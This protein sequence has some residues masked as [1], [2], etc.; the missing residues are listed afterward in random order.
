MET[1]KKI[2]DNFLIEVNFITQQFNV[3]IEYDVD[4]IAADQSKQGLFKSLNVHSNIS[5]SKSLSAEFD[6]F[7]NA[8]QTNVK[9]YIFGTNHGGFDYAIDLKDG[10]VALLEVGT[11]RFLF[12]IAKDEVSFMQ[13]LTKILQFENLYDKGI[14]VDGALIRQ[15]R[16]EAIHLAG[17]FKYAKLYENVI[18]SEEDMPEGPFILQ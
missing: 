17:G 12:E 18:I 9:Y 11:G 13:A 6:F 2:I 14:Q 16:T 4:R 10:F 15:I 3:T 1:I 5:K 8:P 7:Y